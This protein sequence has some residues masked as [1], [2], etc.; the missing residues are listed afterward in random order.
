MA[1]NKTAGSSGELDVVKKVPCPHCGKPL[2]QLPPNY[3]LYDLQ[4]TGCSFRA[5]VKTNRSKP[6]A[7]I[8]GAG[9]E[10]MNKVMKSGFL[11]P[12]LIA[13]FKWTDKGASKQEILFFP[14]I[15]KKNLRRYQLSENAKRANHK[16]FNYVDLLDLPYFVVYKHGS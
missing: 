14:F 1:G 9:W 13:N 2:M 11:I 6:K 5:Q 7:E 8:F 4:C 10:I 3:P 15:P 16:T 12:P